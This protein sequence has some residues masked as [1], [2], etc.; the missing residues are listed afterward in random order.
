MSRRAR[1]HVRVP[2]D[3]TSLFDVLFIVI[4]VVL[5]RA[6]AVQNAAAQAAKPAPAPPSVPLAPS[7]LHVKALAQLE[8]QLAARPVVIVRIAADG[9]LTALEL[10]GRR[11]PLDLPLLEQSRDPD[12]A[13]SYLGE[14][15]AELR[16]CRQTVL[17]L[18]LTDLAGH[19]V[20]FAP[21]V[22][23][24]DLPHALYEGLRRDVERCQTEQRG[25]A[26]V[27]EPGADTANEGA[28]P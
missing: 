5:I 19:L 23:N 27:V 4:F 28:K 2:P 25:L 20:I 3:L 9:K 22:R 13:L 16:V 11:V 14:R 17:Q 15:S 18:G 24:A 6:A 21:D 12:V 1:R 10:G 26:V 8:Q 7:A